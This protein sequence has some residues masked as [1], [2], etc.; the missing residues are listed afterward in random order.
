[1]WMNKNNI[2]KSIRFLMKPWFKENT[3]LIAAY[4]VIL[5]V[6]PPISSY[7]YTVLPQKSFSALEE[8]GFRTAIQVFSLY[9]AFGF[10]CDFIPKLFDAFFAWRSRPMIGKIEK[11]IYSK[12]LETDQADLESPE[13]YDAY[14]LTTESFAEKSSSAIDHVI[15]IIGSILTSLLMGTLIFF[16]GGWALILVLVFSMFAILSNILWSNLVSDRSI[17]A[18]SPKRKSDYIR[19]LFYDPNVVADLK[20]SRIR[21]PLHAMLDQSIQ[22]ETKI[23]RSF[24][25][26]ESLVD[27]CIVLA[28][29]GAIAI[30]P[31]YSILLYA[32][33]GEFDIGTFSTLLL[34][35][36]HLKA[37]LN[38]LGW[39]ISQLSADAQYGRSM[40]AFFEKESTIEAS[41]DGILPQ[42][43]PFQVEIQ[44][45][46]FQYPGNETF[47]LSIDHLRI[48][49]GQKIAVVGENGAG[50][51]TLFKLLLRLYEADRGQILYNN[52]EIDR[53]QIHALRRSIGVAMQTPKI[54]ALNVLENAKAY[55]DISEE[56]LKLLYKKLKIPLDPNT[57]LTKEFDPEGVVLS[58]GQQQKLALSRLMH[59]SFN[60]LLFDE[61]NSALDP[62][63]ELEVSKLIRNIPNT[64]SILV[65]HRLSLVKNA[66]YIYVMNQ[67]SICEAGTHAELMKEKGIYYRMYESQARSYDPD[68][69]DASTEDADL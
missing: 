30:I 9:L 44:D 34:A 35:S 7:F 22:S 24:F 14:K 15:R 12:A 61:P 54:Y 49:P 21:K 19:R 16:Q 31:L 63:A 57:Q 18:M 6:L 11:I 39:W 27:L 20:I 58:G 48:Q 65:A 28:N 32:K 37:S 23:Y 38:E 4:M 69:S 46:F 59:G 1:M 52:V 10:L 53:Y 45:L 13:F 29:L 56:D 67:G 40:I 51:S 25:T 36:T 3:G 64:S 66:D 42:N 17:K 2:W 8:T 26:K 60:L 41:P 43:A 55:R 68:L 33:T 50:K 62:F 47:S 5:S